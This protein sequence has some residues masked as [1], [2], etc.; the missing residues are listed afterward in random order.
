M[1]FIETIAQVGITILSPWAMLLVARKNKWGFVVGL[2]S[3]PF[4]LLIKHKKLGKWLPP[5]GHMEKN[6]TPDDALQRELME[7]LGIKIRI[8]NR[9][10][11]PIK[12]RAVLQLALPIRKEFPA[13]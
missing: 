2:L 7:E 5:G 10:D 6:E 12:G 11:L 4:W 13:T 8:L 9:H 1:A 3:Q